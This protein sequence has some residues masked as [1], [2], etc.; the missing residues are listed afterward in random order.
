[1]E[2]KAWAMKKQEVEINRMDKKKEFILE[3]G[4]HT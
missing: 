3:K 1:V 4:I 2:L